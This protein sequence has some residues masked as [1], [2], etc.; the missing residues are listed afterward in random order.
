MNILILTNKMPYP[1]NDGGAIATMSMAVAFADAG[2]QVTILAMNTSKHFFD[3]ARIPVE[4]SKK[5]EFHG[6]YLNTDL[7]AGKALKNL[8]ISSIP[9]NAQRFISEEFDKKIADL[10]KEKEY[11][12]IQLEGIYVGP[13]IRTIRKHS[14]ALVSMRAH[15]VEHEI[16]ERTAGLAKGFKKIYLRNLAKRIKR[17]EISMI[18]NY[19]VLVPITER[20]AKRFLDFGCR[21]PVHVAPTGINTANLKPGFENFDF[22]NLFHLG[23]LDWAPNQ[24]GLKWFF[25]KVWPLVRKEH[26]SLKFYLA[27]RNAPPYFSSMN[28]PNVVFL[29]EVENAHAFIRSKAIMIVPLLSGSG[30]RIKIIEGMALGKAIVTTGIGIEGINGEHKQNVMIADDAESFARA[31]HYLLED[32]NRVINMGK[33]ASEF[34]FRHYDNRKIIK[35]LITFYNQNLS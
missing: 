32:N 16:W 8:L 28:I 18:N 35:S 21:I 6:V 7:S 4:L 22:P 23:A 5:I 2:N 29:G 1:P 33:Q 20:D 14:K 34:I 19:D 11:D 17:F 13:Y 25:S 31:I 10:L 24:E 15:N 26:P 9:Y 3:V 27:G 30:L 12:I